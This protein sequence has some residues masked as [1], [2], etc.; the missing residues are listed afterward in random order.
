MFSLLKAKRP[1][2]MNT[3]RPSKTSGRRVSPNVSSPFSTCCAL[4]RF[5]ARLRGEIEK[6]SLRDNELIAQKYR[7]FGGDQF[8]HLHA[9][10]NLSV[11]IALFADLDR[12]LCEMTAVGSNPCRHR[13]VSLPNH[14]IHRDGRRPPRSATVD[15][16]VR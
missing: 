10:K 5:H 4:R 15:G 3:S 7:A 16:Q 12:P 6:S 1:A 8:A 11:A 13:T 2:P 9:V 14:P